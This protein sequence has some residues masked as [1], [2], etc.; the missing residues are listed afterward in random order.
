MSE[1]P[2]YDH[3]ALLK[4]NAEGDRKLTAQLGVYMGS[5]SIAIFGENKGGPLT[6]IGLPTMRRS[7]IIAYLQRAIKAAP[8]SRD[9][10]TISDWDNEARRRVSAGEIIVGRDSA[11][12]IYIAIMHKGLDKPVKFPV[13]M[14][15]DTDMSSSMD[16]PQSSNVAAQSIISILQDQVPV[17]EVITKIKRQ[18]NGGGRNNGSYGSNNRGGYSGGNGGSG[19]SNTTASL[20]DDIPF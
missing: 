11:N 9:S 17:A 5:T 13:R 20:D 8:E 12:I 19:Q 3:N 1:L 4:L 7:A 2:N 6:K 16:A 10:F 18:N 15:L 14:P